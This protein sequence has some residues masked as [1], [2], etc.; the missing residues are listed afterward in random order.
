[1][2]RRICRFANS[3]TTMGYDFILSKT[4]LIDTLVDSRRLGSIVGGPEEFTPLI[5]TGR[6]LYLQ[7]MLRLEDRFVAAIGAG[8]LVIFQHRLSTTLP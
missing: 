7:K 3:Y 4:S 6:H 8:S 5:I 2:P 1:M